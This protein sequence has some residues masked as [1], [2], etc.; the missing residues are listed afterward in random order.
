LKGLI[1]N[2]V[3]HKMADDLDGNWGT[4]VAYRPVAIVLAW[5][6]CRVGVPPIAVTVTAFGLLPL[7]ATVAIIASP[8]KAILGLCALG[9]LY[10][11]VDCI[12]GTIARALGLESKFGYYADLSTDLLYRVVFYGALG[13][14]ADRLTASG[15]S[16]LLSVALMAAWLSL[17][18]RI[19]SLYGERLSPRPVSPARQSCDHAS[20]FSWIHLAISGIDALLPFTA[21][22]FWWFDVL[23]LLPFWLL[24]YGAADAVHAQARTMLA[25]RRL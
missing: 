8:T 21:L 14:V 9:V 19:A 6:L 5:P 4:L 10:W 13:H 16:A 23:P 17:F 15:S 18:A 11:V 2:Y 25:V 12:D 20:V 24:I 22:A 1:E 3:R 7:I